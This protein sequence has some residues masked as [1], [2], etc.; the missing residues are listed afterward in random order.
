MNNGLL[1]VGYCCRKVLA[2]DVRRQTFLFS[3]ENEKWGG[4]A[5]CPQR[6]A[7]PDQQRRAGD[8]TPYQLRHFRSKRRIV[9]DA[10][11]SASLCRRLRLCGAL[12]LALTFFVSPARA[13]TFTTN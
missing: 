10:L 13:V 9:F 1:M 8:S 12:L 4:R 3:I 11:I 6:A 5:R 7:R 2:A